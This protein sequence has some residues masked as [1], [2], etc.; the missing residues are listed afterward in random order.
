MF[1]SLGLLDMLMDKCGAT[2]H[3]CIGT[4]EFMQVLIQMLNSKEMP[5]EVSRRSNSADPAKGSLPD[6]EVG[7]KIRIAA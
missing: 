2:F 7:P 5:Q 4:K 1:L 6:S 3:L